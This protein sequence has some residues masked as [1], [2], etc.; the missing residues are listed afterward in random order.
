MK[1]IR[2]GVKSI[3][4]LLLVALLAITATSV[5]RVYR[6]AEPQPF[7][8]AKIFNPY[9][10]FSSEQGWKRANFHTHTRVDGLLNE[11]E[12]TPE[13]TLEFYERFGYDIV[14]YSNHNALTLHPRD[15]Q[16]QVNLY[17]HG[18]NLFKFHKLVFG[19]EKVNRFDHLLPFF[20]SQ[21]QMQIDMLA[22]QSDIIVLNHPLRTHLTT[23]KLLERLSGYDIIELD[24]GKSTENDYWDAAL[25][26]GH[27]SFGLANDDL[28]YP[29]RTGAIAVR[30]NFL[31]T[32]SARYEDI[33]RTLIEGCFYAMRL[34]DY[35]N[36]DWQTKV[37]RNKCIPYIKNIGVTECGSVYIA[38]SEQADNIKITGQNHSTLASALNADSLSYTMQPN[39]PYCRITAHFADG[40]VIYTNP[41]AR[42]DGAEN[43]LLTQQATHSVDILLTALFNIALAILFIGI[44]TILYKTI[45][46]W[47]IFSSK[48]DR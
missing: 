47:Q 5:S 11:C 37:E 3:I 10:N 31:Q 39:D 4:S 45:F 41:F 48:N 28:H 17:E 32:P 2:I 7:S 36:G 24:S 1:F 6:F 13:Q 43:S 19:C 44:G 14:T 46:V 9:R 30:C 34:P 8:G 40:E 18:Y 16:L 12:Y 15:P 23:T 25:S 27:Y 42:Y 20:A 22:Q 35:G 33:V 21:R 29:D 38:L 26:A